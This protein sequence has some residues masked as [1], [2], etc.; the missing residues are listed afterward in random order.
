M[1]TGIVSTA[2]VTHATPAASYAY[3]PDRNWESDK[4]IEPDTCVG[5]ID[6]IAVQLLEQ[7]NYMN[8]SLVTRRCVHVDNVDN[9]YHTYGLYI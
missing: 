1:S 7:N 8:V 2:R 9:T 4:D 5:V 3:S 6:D